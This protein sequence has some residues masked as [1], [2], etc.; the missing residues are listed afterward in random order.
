[1]SVRRRRV[2]VV[3]CLLQLPW[4]L[5]LIRKEANKLRMNQ[6]EMKAELQRLHEQSNQWRM[7]AHMLQ[8]LARVYKHMSEVCK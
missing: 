5:E 8:S 7:A 4:D 2:V 1:V 3:Y 6:V